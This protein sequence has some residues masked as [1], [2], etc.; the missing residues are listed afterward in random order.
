MVSITSFV[1]DV[2]III[3]ILWEAIVTASS[4][5]TL[6]VLQHSLLH[7]LPPEIYVNMA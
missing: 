3:P 6:L 4:A 7:S 2:Y 5:A 1:T